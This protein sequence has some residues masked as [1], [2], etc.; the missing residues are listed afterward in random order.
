MESALETVG[1]QRENVAA[2][3]AKVS[4]MAEDS[5]RLFVRRDKL[6]RRY[7]SLPVQR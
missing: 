4:D 7:R 2:V 3:V 5:R 1:S 6:E